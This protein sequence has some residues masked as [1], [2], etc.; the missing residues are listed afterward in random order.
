M[1]HSFLSLPVAAAGKPEPC[2]PADGNSD[3][4]NRLLMRMDAE[5]RV[6]WALEHLP[7]RH[8]L[9]SSFGVQAAV[10]LHLVNRLAPGIPVVFLDTG[11]LFPETYRFAD[12]LTARLDLN[13]KVYRA[14]TSAA[15]QEARFGRLWQEGEA[16]LE[17]YHQLNKI[18]PMQRAL[19]ELGAGTWF[20]GLRR[21]QSS[22][23]THVAF[24]ED[25]D[26]CCKCHP[27]ADWSRHDVARYL[28][29][30]DLPYHPL[31]QEGYVSVGDTHTTRPAKPGM[32]PEDTRFF[33]LK[34][35]CGLHTEI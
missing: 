25:R 27:L 29:R 1:P 33:G 5:A 31:W 9:S 16:G 20:A 8:V 11:Y 21:A 32:A 34:R 26:G 4:E 3:R 19:A 6:A 13:V 24:V 17:R 35:E 15:W 2:E 10:M 23:R 12:E 14:E 28:K 30:Y 18:E 22:S 7:G